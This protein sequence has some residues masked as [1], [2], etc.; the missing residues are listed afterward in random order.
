MILCPGGWFSGQY[1]RSS[2]YLFKQLTEWIVLISVMILHVICT[3]FKHLRTLFMFYLCFFDACFPSTDFLSFKLCF[4]QVFVVLHFLIRKLDLHLLMLSS[5][6]PILLSVV[7]LDV[8][9]MQSV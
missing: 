8:V 1:N 7:K 5:F 9:S 6:R 3:L 4:I 2:D